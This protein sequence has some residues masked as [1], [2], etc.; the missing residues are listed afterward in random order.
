M[1]SQAVNEGI[2]KF[3]AHKNSVPRNKHEAMIADLQ[4]RGIISSE[5]AAA[6][7]RIWRSFRN[8]VHH[9]NPAVKKVPFETLA[10]KNLQDLSVIEKE[11][12]GVDFQ[13]GR[14]MPRQPKYWD[15]E[16]NGT[17]PVFLRLGI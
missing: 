6:S 11:I 12:F 10:R 5:C 13:D 7:D 3:V 14:L 4:K 2:L 15:I 17:V 16:K 9:M 8:D 1:V